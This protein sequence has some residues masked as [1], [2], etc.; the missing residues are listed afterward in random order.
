MKMK[1]MKTV[2]WAISD[3]HFGH[4][5]MIRKGYRS[6]DSSKRILDNLS[7]IGPDDVLIHL[8][9]MSFYACEMWHK[10]FFNAVPCRRKWLIKGNHDRKSNSWYIDQGW[11]CICDEMTMKLYGFNIVFSHRPLLVNELYSRGVDTINVHGHTHGE[12]RTYEKTDQH[13]LVMMEH[14][15]MPIPVHT[16]VGM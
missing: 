10:V 3:T 14:E 4:H 1:R 8:G 9:D 11:D 7:V 2:F 5:M 6:P 15:Y 12:H 13:R 16:L